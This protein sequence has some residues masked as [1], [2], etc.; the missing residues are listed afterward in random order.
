MWNQT[1]IL[2]LLL[3]FSVSA[4][5]VQTKP[6]PLP[7]LSE[8][9]NR[10]RNPNAKIP[11]WE[12]L[13]KFLLNDDSNQQKYI[14]DVFDCKHF[15][16]ELFRRAQAAGFQCS[17]TVVDYV[18]NPVGHCVVGFLTVEKGELFADFIPIV[19][20]D[21]QLPAKSFDLLQ[22][23]MP[24][25][26]IPLSQ[27]TDDF[28]NQPQ[29]FIKYVELQNQLRDAKKLLDT[30]AL[31]IDEMTRAIQREETAIRDAIAK[32]KNTKFLASKS[33]DLAAK[34]E[35]LN[36][37]VDKHNRAIKLYNSYL[38]ATQSPYDIQNQP[39]VRGLTRF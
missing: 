6:G 10:Y 30:Q 20:G 22:P 21:K 23:G 36:V 1:L 2:S 39:K 8:V 14:K 9:A 18:D 4:A 15:S 31:Q 3:S 7:H 38:E 29:T 28:V 16:V 32:E 26:H 37:E 19:T 35:K 24:L 34:G 27:I 5:E 11:T 17:I 12:E 33:K 13:K 25:I